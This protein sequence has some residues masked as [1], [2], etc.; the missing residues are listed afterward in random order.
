MLVSL[1]RFFVRAI[2]CSALT[3]CSPFSLRR[4]CCLSSLTEMSPP[5]VVSAL[6]FHPVHSSL[7]SAAG[8]DGHIVVFDLRARSGSAFAQPLISVSTSSEPVRALHWPAVAHPSLEVILTA[9]GSSVRS[10]AVSRWCVAVAGGTGGVGDASSAAAAAPVIGGGG[11]SCSFEYLPSVVFPSTLHSSVSSLSVGERNSVDDA[12][13]LL[14][15]NG[16]GTANAVGDNLDRVSTIKKQSGNAR[17]VAATFAC[18]HARV[19]FSFLSAFV[20]V[21]LPLSL[22][23]I[24]NS[25]RTCG[26]SVSRWRLPPSTGAASVKPTFSGEYAAGAILDVS[27][28]F[29]AQN[30][31]SRGQPNISLDHKQRKEAAVSMRL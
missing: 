30:A 5:T 24:G 25:H 22:Q 17:V 6:A 19:S 7:L 13:F 28:G 1:A 11:N 27:D 29:E 3:R 23:P 26:V 10:V 18:A 9:Q 8:I 14:M 12:L 20:F 4:R 31:L 15:A 21:P 16:D 2:F